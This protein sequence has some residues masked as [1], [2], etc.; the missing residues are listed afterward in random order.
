[1]ISRQSQSDEPPFEAYS[2]V[3]NAGR[4]RA[5]HPIALDLL[6]RLA[7]EYDVSRS[8]DFDLLPG[9]EPFEHARPPVRLTPAGV[10]GA[11]I[12]IAFTTFPGLLVRCGRWLVESFPSC[13]CDACG[14]MAEAEGERLQRLLDDVV[15]GRFREEITIP[16]LGR[17]RLA[18]ALGG[19]AA[20]ATRSAWS[21]VSRRRARALV[22]DGARE[23]QWHPWVRRLHGTSGSTALSDVV[24]PLT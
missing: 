8:A 24:A 23:V 11:P 1:M 7:A 21:V 13:G 19:G 6:Q 4:F 2:R 10:T 3:T 22:V 14:E 9:M 18:W 17:A 15:A 16:L 5:L 20:A 12:A